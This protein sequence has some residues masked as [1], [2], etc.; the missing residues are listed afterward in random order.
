MSEKVCSPRK[1]KAVDWD[2]V[3]RTYLVLLLLGLLCF[4]LLKPAYLKGETDEALLPA[5]S[6]LS[7]GNFGVSEAE[8]ERAYSWFPEWR[9]SLLQLNMSGRLDQRG[10]EMSYYFPTYATVSSIVMGALKVLHLP[11]IHTFSLTNVLCLMGMLFLVN[12]HA[13]LQGFPKLLLLIALSINPILAYIDW[14]SMEVLMYCLLCLTAL[15]WCNHRY[16]VAAVLLSIA[17]TMNLTV[18]ATGF[19]MIFDCL[20]T[21]ANERSDKKFRY[22]L[23]QWKRIVL[24]G[25]C[26]LI[27]FIPFVYN[28][29]Q[30][31][32]VNIIIGGTL[33]NDP[34]TFL[35]WGD[36]LARLWCYLTDLNLGYLP[37]YLPTMIAFAVLVVLSVIRHKRQ[38][39]LILGAWL[40][41]MLCYSFFSHINCG[42]EGIARYNAWSSALILMAVFYLLPEEIRSILPS[43]KRLATIGLC[44]CVCFTI[45][46]TN[47][48]LSEWSSSIEYT[49]LARLVLKNAPEL[50]NP[51]YSTFNNRSNGID[52]GYE[53]TTP[54]VY[55]DEWTNKILLKAGEGEEVLNRLYATDAQKNSIRAQLAGKQPDEYVYLSFSDREKVLYV[56]VERDYQLGT[57][58]NFA[59]S[60]GDLSGKMYCNFGFS[61][62]ESD[63]TWTEQRTARMVLA[64]SDYQD[65][66]L[67]GRISC[68][69]VL[70]EAQQVSIR[71][72]DVIVYDGIVS[73]NDPIISFD[74]PA[75]CVYSGALRIDFSFPQAHSPGTQDARLL[76]IAIESMTFD[77][78]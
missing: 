6:I 15:Y 1:K 5:V 45:T 22:L 16:H 69:T 41:T 11:V 26:Y 34:D 7:S 12:R 48:Y 74:I 61:G 37:Y 47:F 76:G 65:G 42:M 13:R 36:T 68:R 20:L 24:Y 56:D 8:K 25:C 70:G 23:S 27:V 10:E 40:L 17:G 46:S 58:L 64:I 30:I 72:N 50:Y 73:V 66:N 54:V 78:Q 38:P 28:Y 35:H 44:F 62:A 59:Q 18:M 53:I 29:V 39:L 31:G 9:D 19:F 55:T 43:R 75:D 77:A 63:F 57:M 2:V 4:F 52:G 67:T 51:L 71:V 32:T 33:K 21:V 3:C 60:K 49:P 14:P